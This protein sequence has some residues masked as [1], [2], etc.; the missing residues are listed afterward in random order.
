LYLDTNILISALTPIDTTHQRFLSVSRVC[1]N[2]GIE[3]KFCQ[4]SLDELRHT[5][6]TQTAFIRQMNGKIPR[7]SSEKIT[8]VFH[9]VHRHAQANNSPDPDAAF[10]NFYNPI[11]V[12]SEY[13]AERVDDE[14]FV[15]E[16]SKV[17]EDPILQK[18]RNACTR[19]TE[20]G[21]RRATRRT[22]SEM[23]LD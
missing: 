7:A 22:T 10:E 23:G 14:W 1:A 6:A 18:V 12:L 17:D 4:I 20:G 3:L 5:V 8:N 13:L 19:P 11:P 21:Q 9:M 2:L 16:A 15:T